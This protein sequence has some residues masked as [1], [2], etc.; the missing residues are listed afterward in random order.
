MHNNAILFNDGIL[1]IIRSL[2]EKKFALGIILAG[3]NYASIFTAELFYW[4]DLTK[5]KNFKINNKIY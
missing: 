1:I 2:V 5:K 3:A 4:R